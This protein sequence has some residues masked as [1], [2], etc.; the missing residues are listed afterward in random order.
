MAKNLGNIVLQQDAVIDLA[1]KDSIGVDV[2]EGGRLTN[3]AS[4][5]CMS[6]MGL[7]FAPLAKDAQIKS[8]APLWSMTVPQACC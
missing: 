8:W 6:A 1:S 3:N 7:A 5:H 2:Q 4:R